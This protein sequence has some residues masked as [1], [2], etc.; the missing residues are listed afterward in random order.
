MTKFYPLASSSKGNCSYIGT[1][2]QGI[3][4]DVGIGPRVLQSALSLGG[5]DP[6]AIKAVFVTHEHSD[7]VK[8]LRK[9]TERYDVPVYGSRET[10]AELIQRD[11]VAPHTKLYEINRRS[12]EIAGMQVRAFTTSHDSVHS[13]GYRIDTP[14]GKTMAFCT[15]LGVVTPEVAEHLEGCDLV[16]IESNYDKQ[17]LRYGAYPQYLKRRIASDTGH[18]SNDGCS[19]EVAR[20]VNRGSTQFVLGHLSEENNRPEIALQ[21]TVKTLEQNGMK[22]GQDYTV[23]VAPK[24]TTGISCDI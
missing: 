21:Q 16:M 23:W 2:K 19:E 5:F 8:G 3:F 6:M 11:C 4:I 12:V 10:L 7:H 24:T 18:L 14:G 22:F 13:L 1:Q 9:F 17:M 15:D 20:L